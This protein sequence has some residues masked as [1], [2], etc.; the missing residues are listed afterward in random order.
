MTEFK[1]FSQF[2]LPSNLIFS[3]KTAFL[4]VSAVQSLTST[5]ETASLQHRWVCYLTVCRLLSRQARR[6]PSWWCSALQRASGCS[7]TWPTTRRRWGASGSTSTA[8]RFWFNSF[9][10]RDGALDPDLSASLCLMMNGGVCCS[11]H[12]FSLKLFS[13][14]QKSE[15]PLGSSPV[16]LCRWKIC[17]RW[18]TSHGKQPHSFFWP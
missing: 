15:E 3:L 16:L 2:K 9:G 4:D 1:I 6:P 14:G 17:M 11:S 18:R 5:V 12:A 8:F 10:N 13:K 7:A